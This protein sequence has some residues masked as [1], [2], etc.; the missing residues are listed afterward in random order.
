MATVVTHA[1]FGSADRLKELQEQ[2][3][4]VVE[5]TRGYDDISLSEPAYGETIVGELEESEKAIFFALYDA[6]TALEDLTRTL[7]GRQ[8]TRVGQ[9]ITDS[10]RSKTLQ[11]AMRDEPG[12][13][14]FDS[15]EEAKEFFRLE[16]KAA[17]L[18]STFHFNLAD[19]LGR[20]EFKLGVRTRGRVVAAERRY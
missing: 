10:D 16:K 4:A 14:V 6:T 8:L 11:E 17:M 3:I 18:H 5:E 2:G 12:E 9:R 20:H 1:R 15:D 19:R 13:L 7:M